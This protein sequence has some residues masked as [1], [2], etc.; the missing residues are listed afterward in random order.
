[1]LTITIVQ[2]REGNTE[3]T[4]NL[5]PNS[6]EKALAL[7]AAMNIVAGNL[8]KAVAVELEQLSQQPPEKEQDNVPKARIK[9]D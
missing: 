9:N 6:P 2:D 4:H 8:A 3:V 1:M 5:P 7:V